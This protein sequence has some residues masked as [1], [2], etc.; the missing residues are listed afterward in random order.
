MPQTKARQPE[1][2][3][4]L[5]PFHFVARETV[6]SI[7]NSLAERPLELLQIQRVREIVAKERAQHLLSQDDVRN[8]DNMSAA[9]APFTVTRNL[10]A[11]R[12]APGLDRPSIMTSAATA[13]ER[14]RRD[15]PKL[16]VLSIGPRSEIEI[17]ALLAAG[18][19]Q[20]KIRAID[21]FSYSPLVQLGDMHAIPFPDNSFDIVFV[22]WVMT[23]SRD[24]QLVAREIARVARDKAI[25]VL[26]GD[27][28]DETIDHP[29]FAGKRQYMSSCDQLLSLF[30]E[31]IGR[32]Y[33][34]HDASPPDVWMVM[35]V[36]ELKK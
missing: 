26:A 6:S 13:I 17:F 2:I 12:S 5:D 11:A 32:V 28:C 25:I 27:Y 34:R 9:I 29:D 1:V 23:Y 7:L 3:D 14:V 36:F 21:L 24:H 22:G 30:P 35:T 15:A 31:N 19:S 20:N 18:F 4:G 8:V 16:D 10:D 33:F